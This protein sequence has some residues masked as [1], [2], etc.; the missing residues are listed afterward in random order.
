MDWISECLNSWRGEI[1]DT[2][3]ENATVKNYFNFEMIIRRS[4]EK[5]AAIEIK[6]FYLEDQI[7]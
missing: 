2:K 1:A 6:I 5:Q 7:I 4:R 3:E